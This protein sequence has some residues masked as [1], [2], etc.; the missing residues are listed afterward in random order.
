MKNQQGFILIELIAVIIIVGIIATFTGFFL[1]SGFTGY[2]TMKNTTEGALNAQM[3]LDR[4]SLELRNIKEIVPPPSTTS[5]TYKSEKFTGTRILKYFKEGTEE[6]GKI[7][8][9][10]NNTDYT[11]LENI[12]PDTF[13]VT[14]TY[15]NLDHDTAPVDEVEGID[16]RF[17]LNEIGKEFRA[18][19]FPRNLVPKTW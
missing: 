2:L 11:L 8:I 12:Q 14:L 19:V 7:F 16:V 17:K 13:S 1:Y 9:N 3:A 10:I 6:T 4:I 18:Q 5:I 15:L